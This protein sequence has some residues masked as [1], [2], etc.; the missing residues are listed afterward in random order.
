MIKSEIVRN[1]WETR[2]PGLKGNQYSVGTPEFFNEVEQKR[3]NI[4]YRYIKKESEFKE[5]KGKK[6]LE[7]GVGFGTEI[8]NYARNGANVFGIDLTYNAIKMTN[9]R[10]KQENLKGTFKQ[11][12]FKNLPFRDCSFDLV[13]SWGVLHHSKETQQGIN[14]IFRVLKPGGRFIIMLY[15]KGFKYYIKKLFYHGVLRG[16]YLKSSSQQIV[17]KHSENNGDCPLTKA[18]NRK[19]IRKMFSK[20]RKLEMTGYRLDDHFY[21]GGKIFSPIKFFLP[22]CL[23]RPIENRWGW[24]LLIKGNKPR[25]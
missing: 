20:Y 13:V 3:Y 18:Y 5:Y 2:H 8:I 10:F 4:L 21:W 24:N 22:K 25:V 19:E 23:W 9:K 6:V 12:N 15:H 17:S 7:I 1:Y 14:E 11:A 16:E